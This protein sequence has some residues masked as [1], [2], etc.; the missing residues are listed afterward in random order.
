MDPFMGG[1][2][3][4]IAAKKLG[5]KSIGFEVNPFS[6]FLSQCKLEN[7]TKKDILKFRKIINEMKNVDFSKISYQLPF[8]SFAYK[9]FEKDIETYYMKIWFFI[10]NLKI[11]KKI[12]NLLKLGWLSNLEFFSNYRKAGNGLKIKKKKKKIASIYEV[13]NILLNSYEQMYDDILHNKNASTSPFLINDTCL[14]MKKYIKDSS[15]NGIIFSPPYANCFDYTEIYKLELW[16]GDFISNYSEL[17][18]LRKKTLRSNLSSNLKDF[19]NI[20]ESS[21]LNFLLS[22]LSAEKLWDPKIPIMLK[23]YFSDMFRCINNCYAA[24]SKNSFCCIIIGNSSYN[25]I[26]FPTDLIIAEYA[27]S[28]GFKINSINIG[29]YIITSSQQY[30]KTKNLKKYLRESVVCLTK[31]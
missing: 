7:Y 14:N 9:V 20:I 22:K 16:F 1:A 28:I 29:R 11:S 18:D 27:R 30:N 10:K 23:L 13:L 25:N 21:T 19:S 17:K 31:N 26:V 3:T 8:L 6:Y 15:I 5:F 4:L 2:T 12:K 24:L